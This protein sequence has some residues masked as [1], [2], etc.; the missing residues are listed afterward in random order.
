MDDTCGV[1]RRINWVRLGGAVAVA[2]AFV[3]IIYGF[4]IAETGVPR[5]QLPEGLEAI[6]PSPGATEQRQTEITAD[7][8]SEWEGALVV[9]GV[10]IPPDQLRVDEGQAIIAF[11]AR[12]G[13]EVEEYL[14][15]AVSVTVIFWRIADGEGSASTNTWT[16][17]FNVS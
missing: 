16:W 11:Q 1:F 3:M 6:S 14:N 8:A 2:L 5:Q 7:F 12:R 15:R 9:N 10:R 4:S 13:A 17:S